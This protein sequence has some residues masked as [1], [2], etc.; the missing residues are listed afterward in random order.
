MCP[1]AVTRRP[2]WPDG[3]TLSHVVDRLRLM[4]RPNV[5]ITAPPEDLV[6]ERDV[7]VEVRDGTVLRVNVFR[8]P[9]P[10]PFPTLLSAHPY[11]KDM[12]PVA[13]RGAGYRTPFQLRLLPQSQPFSFSALTSWE[14]PD[15]AVWTGHGYAVVNADLR[16]W[17]TSDG[18]GELLSAQEGR[19]GHDIVEW[20]AE[21]PWSTG[22][23][24][25]LGVSYLAI[26]QWAVAA[27]R[28]PHLA[29]ICPWEGFSDAYHDFARRGG[30]LEDGFLRM[31]ALSLRRQRRS[32]VTIRREARRRPLF[33]EWWRER[34]RDLERIDVPVLACASFSDHNLHS[35]GTFAGWERVASADRRLHTHRGPKWATFYSP[36]AVA[37][38]REFFDEMLKGPRG[39]HRGDSL[40]NAPVRLEV[41]S[42]ATTV[43]SVRHI[44]SWPPD[45]MSE[46]ALHLH[47][48]GSLAEDSPVSPCTVEFNHRGER[49][50]F[51]WHIT[52]D[53]ELIGA[54]RL[55]LSLEVVDADDVALF[56]GARKLRN[57]RVVGFEGSY[58]FDRA[59][60][61]MGMRRA[62]LREGLQPRLE[63]LA[64]GDVVAV[65]IELAPSAT[66]FVAGEEL[67]LDIQ[68]R[69]FFPTNPLVGQF[70]ARYSLSQR[71]RSRLYLGGDDPGVLTVP[72]RPLDSAGTIQ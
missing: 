55:R 40:P 51:S 69:W 2:R 62:S 27:E 59:L 11:G 33:D 42:D 47:P 45:D 15:P 10:G 48:D 5:S 18:V 38:Q 53:V 7:P 66:S 24:G 54:M 72:I 1:A 19:D 20:V 41:R 12:L 37:A 36:Q 46:V 39:K 13:R 17:G 56:V 29:A 25:M 30:V 22:R 23:I 61:S 65:E 35:T 49:A 9:G 14:A 67:R 68:G 44:D 71:G 31:W 43:T 8:P 70:P 57:G 50:T 63:P 60:L 4:A 58:G 34:V 6:I 26:S 52:S 64:P 32:P 21:Q 28:P 3:V 16:G